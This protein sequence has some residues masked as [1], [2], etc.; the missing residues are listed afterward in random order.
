VAQTTQSAETMI[1]L[2]M[3][4]LMLNRLHPK[5]DQAEFRYRIAP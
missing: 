5:D 2:S 3:I 1:R 4:H